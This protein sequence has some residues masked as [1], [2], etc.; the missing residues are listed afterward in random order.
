[1]SNNPR[2]SLPEIYQSLGISIIEAHKRFGRNTV[3]QAL[4]EEGIKSTQVW[5]AMQI[6]TNFTYEQAAGFASLR[7][8]VG[9][10]SKNRNN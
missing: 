2:T 6:A 8:I 9:A 7:D 3:K 5:R 10:I 4:R 1:M